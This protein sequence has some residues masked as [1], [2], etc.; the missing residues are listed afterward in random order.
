MRPARVVLFATVLLPFAASCSRPEAS[1]E[2]A[3]SQR[4]FPVAQPVVKR[5]VIR[6]NYVA[7]IEALRHADLRARIKGTLEAVT[8]DEGARVH[9]GQLLFSINARART[10]DVAVARAAARAEEAELH[11]AQLEMQNTKLLADKDIVST[12]ELNRAQ[13]KTAMLEAKVEE[14]NA[15]AARAAA[16]LD[17]ADVRAP[18]DGVVD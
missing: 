13:S 8:V 5:V 17:R 15:L 14:A 11:S 3:E 6:R 7:K 16:E 18:F 9:K 4:S 10:Q 2:A 12:A 1:A